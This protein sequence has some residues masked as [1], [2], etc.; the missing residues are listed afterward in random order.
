MKEFICS[1]CGNL[2]KY[3]GSMRLPEPQILGSM[4]KSE[5]EDRVELHGKL[6]I[7]DSKILLTKANLNLKI[8]T[9]DISMLWVVWVKLDI[10]EFINKTKNVSSEL[11]KMKGE[12]VSEIP[13]YENTIGT[14]VN[15]FFHSIDLEKNPQVEILNKET[16]LEKDYHNGFS[17]NDFKSWM[18]KVL[19]HPLSNTKQTD[20]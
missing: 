3:Y 11:V 5:R 18:E 19:Y 10:H 14:G 12:L 13:N 15:L 1:I 2:H 4:S 9:M 16:K 17:I 6:H 7:V 20:D 8:N